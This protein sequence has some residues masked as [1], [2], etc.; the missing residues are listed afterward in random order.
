MQTEFLGDTISSQVREQFAQ[1][2]ELVEV[3][4]FGQEAGCKYWEDTPG[5]LREKVGLSDRSD[6]RVYDLIGA[7]AEA[8]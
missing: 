8:I 2:Q 1:L 7:A 5:L 6:L 3:L 4:F